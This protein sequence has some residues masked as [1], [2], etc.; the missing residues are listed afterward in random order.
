MVWFLI[1]QMIVKENWGEQ[2]ELSFGMAT[3]NF[4]RGNITYFT[5]SLGSQEPKMRSVKS[6]SLREIKWYWRCAQL[7]L[8]ID[9]KE[10][11][12]TQDMKEI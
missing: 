9:Y 8:G 12:D 11:I 4:W 10:H 5:M 6:A 3:C 7:F 1:L 2:S